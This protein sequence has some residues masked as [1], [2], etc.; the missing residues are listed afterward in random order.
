MHSDSNII[1]PQWEIFLKA[2]SD[3]ITE[4]SSNHPTVRCWNRTAFANIVQEIRRRE[5]L[6]SSF[7]NTPDILNHLINIGWAYPIKVDV[8]SATSTPSKEFYVLEIGAANSANV[9][10]LELLEAYRPGGIICYLS[11]LTYY[12]LTTQM[13]THHHI[14]VLIKQPEVKKSENLSHNKDI[15]EESENPIRKRSLGELLFTYQGIPCYLTKRLPTMLVGFQTRILGPRTHLRITTLEQTLLDTL[16]K[17]L[18]CGGTPVIFEAWEEGIARF[19]E[20]V[21]NDYLL[22]ISSTSLSRR[23]GAMFDLLDFVPS[24]LLSKT[25]QR[26][27]ELD[28]QQTSLANISLLPGIEFPSLNSKW[29]VMTP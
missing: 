28:E 2:L 5:N 9:D 26:A 3:K 19:D 4:A 1:S 8:P 21:L 12:S 16:H 25:L 18:Y 14:G 10:P 11:A 29:Q 24:D 17:P 15:I 6:P 20:N 27:L 13:P 23:V 22:K 7:P